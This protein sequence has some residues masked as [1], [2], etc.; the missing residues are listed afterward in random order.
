MG[1]DTWTTGPIRNAECAIVHS[2]GTRAPLRALG[3][4]FGMI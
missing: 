1:G 2:L 4:E 3:V